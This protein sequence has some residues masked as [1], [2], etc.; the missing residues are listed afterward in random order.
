MHLIQKKFAGIEIP[1]VLPQSLIPPS[2]RK[3][4]QSSP[5]AP[6]PVP[7]PVQDLFS[8]D[9]APTPVSPA[10]VHQ[11]IGKQPPAP[12]T[13]RNF[14]GQPTTQDP[15]NSSPFNPPGL[16]HSRSPLRLLHRLIISTAQHR[17]LLD[18]DDD[19]HTTPQI[20][21][22]SAEIGNLRNQLTSTAKSLQ[23]IQ[24]ERTSIER[25]VETQASELSSLQTQL[26]VAKAAH[27]TE[28]RLLAT[29]RER[30]ATQ[31]TEIQ[32]VRQ[33]LITE[34]SN[35]SGMRVEKAEIE[36]AF[37]RDK[38]EARELHRKMIEASQ[39]AEALKGEIDKSKKDAK[40]QKGLLAIARKQLSTK[41]ADRAKALRELEESQAE[42]AAISQEHQVI[43][44]EIA[45]LDTPSI[46]NEVAIAASL[47]L[48]VTPEPRP[49]TNLISPKSNNPFE[50]LAIS[51]GHSTPRSQSPFLCS[52]PAVNASL[53]DTFDFEQAFSTDKA[54]S[55]VPLASKTPLTEPDAHKSP[56]PK[57]A[58][59]VP[60]STELPALN[61]DDWFNT[62][63]DNLDTNGNDIGTDPPRPHTP[64]DNVFESV[65]TSP[66]ATRQ[67]VQVTDLGSQLKELDAEESDS[68]NDSEDEIPLS[69]LAKRKT[70]EPAAATTDPLVQHSQTAQPSDF[71]DIFSEPTTEAIKTQEFTTEPT[72]AF[73]MSLTSP[74]API[75]LSTTLAAQGPPLANGVNAFD[76]TLGV[77]ALSKT[78]ETTLGFDGAFDDN[79]DF[80]SA[81]HFPPVGD[82]DAAIPKTNGHTISPPGERNSPLS[83]SASLDLFTSLATASSNGTG[84]P[85][86]IDPVFP[87]G[88]PPHVV[89][90]TSP[91]RSSQSFEEAYAGLA[92]TSA[93][94]SGLHIP[95]DSISSAPTVSHS[96]SAPAVATASSQ[97][98]P[99]PT[100]PKSAS[101]HIT[102]ISPPRLSSPKPRLSSSSSSKEVHDKHDK[103]KE[104]PPSRSK[105]SVSKSQGLL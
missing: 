45:G 31:T 11:E 58:N 24:Q 65:F 88:P 81:S 12:I 75:D 42:L 68:D 93:S 19:T 25:A 80:S 78:P 92:D 60:S 76:E 100:S 77:I 13:P 73:G 102:P 61:V 48:P 40:Q 104:A 71:D 26:A 63:A 62:P 10:P 57:A 18:D 53:N 9:D 1:D 7:E 46:P 47:P 8:W 72:D 49:A 2:L 79:F 5:V 52:P 87:A 86:A 95:A 43:Q 15:F 103:H 66:I 99:F 91:T 44:A 22:H 70:P 36:G 34:E 82:I 35:L 29:L 21:D 39:Q 64:G 3:A 14:N 105:L 50:R 41:E 27:E 23:T 101:T 96:A 67:S 69:A 84:V 85:A 56:V 83:Q 90:P 55:A 54:G 94:I 37:L 38:E 97:F 16:S 17:N 89:A 98:T 51:S 28:T 6:P 20:H 30:H 33:E 4:V 74:S 32:K 59:D